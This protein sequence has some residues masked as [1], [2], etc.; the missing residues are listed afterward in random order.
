MNEATLH[1]LLVEDNPG[2]ARLLRED[3]IEPGASDFQITHVAQ[4]SEAVRLLRSD[5]FHIILLD[6]TLPD[7]DG[8]ETLR[9][10]HG[11]SPRTPVVV[12]TGLDNESL[13]IDAV[14]QG[15]QDY[16]VKDQTDRRLLIRSIHYAIERKHAED[17]LA[18]Y[19]D[20]LEELV[21]HRTA[22]LATTN[23]VL[24]DQMV[25]RARAEEALEAA[26]R[27]LMT[28]RE[29]QR[30]LLASE[31]HDSVGQ[32]LIGLKLALEHVMARSKA[33]LDT[34]AARTLA[35][36]VETCMALIREIR[37]LSHGLYPPSLEAFGLAAA[38]K[39]MTGDA[40]RTCP[41]K[42]ECHSSCETMRFH[43]D[44]EIAVFRI[45]QESI[46][47]AVTHSGAKQIDVKLDCSDGNLN[48]TIVDDG[49]GFTPA[50]AAG[51]GL[52]LISM[53]DRAT[54]VGGSLNIVSRPGETRIEAHIPAEVRP[55]PY[56]DFD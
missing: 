54:T 3:L 34:D 42:L 52:G 15:A 40:G 47:N 6:L 35:G 43:P 7:S 8:L 18:R 26:R 49:A 45:A 39:Q 53:K 14:R 31:L 1:L 32:Q 22:A 50:K 21:A 41:V 38:L 12:L 11:E 24:Q 56:Q 30:R 27:K 4:L 25:E 20:S 51:K 2:D 28:D 55:D 37:S 44:A 5:R 36:T 16:L 23:A 10:I 48:L 9:R 33:S 19:R 17:E 29:Q 46:H 13:G